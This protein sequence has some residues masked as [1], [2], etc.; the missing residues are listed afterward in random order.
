MIVGH[1][2]TIRPSVR[3]G[4][5]LEHSPL[6]MLVPDADGDL[7]ND[8]GSRRLNHI[9]MH[10]GEMWVAHVDNMQTWPEHQTQLLFSTQTNNQAIFVDKWNGSSWFNEGGNIDPN[11][12]YGGNSPGDRWRPARPYLASDGE[13]LYLAY[14]I[15]VGGYPYLGDYRANI[16]V[17]LRRWD[18][19]SWDLIRQFTP[20]TYNFLD[21][22]SFFSGNL[23]CLA[24]PEAVGEPL[25]LWSENGSTYDGTGTPGPT[26]GNVYLGRQ[27][28][29]TT[30]PRDAFNYEF[31]AVYDT[32][33]PYLFHAYLN[34]DV[35]HNVVA[36]RNAFTGDVLQYADTDLVDPPYTT[37]TTLV[38]PSVS[39][40][41]F[42]DGERYVYYVLVAA[43]MSGF[44][45]LPGFMLQVP[46]DGSAPFE[47]LDNNNAATSTVAYGFFVLVQG[48]SLFT[49]DIFPEADNVWVVG[50]L[51]VNTDERFFEEP[52]IVEQYDR[53]CPLDEDGAP[54]DQSGDRLT[55]PGWRLASLDSDP[56]ASPYF[57]IGTTTVPGLNDP[58]NIFAMTST[59]FDGEDMY[60]VGLTG[61]FT[62]FTGT[63]PGPG[64]SQYWS[65]RVYK[66]AIC[67][68]C[69]TCHADLRPYPVLNIQ[70]R[71]STPL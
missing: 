40:R 63:V 17:V 30:I 25:V 56:N 48:R 36:M 38:G 12:H 39:K 32:D 62:G 15:H 28:G 9:C 3:V 7:V 52:A 26:I 21:N 6:Q 60:V 29:S 18:G 46:A 19:A 69:G 71:S 24:S 66:V 16:T 57:G 53:A 35:G 37:T 34:D 4:G 43:G 8:D 31:D 59:I 20:K 14:S 54:G 58:G 70:F 44:V 41:R 64:P 50:P 27:D 2:D 68:G 1:Y 42:W 55:V 49:G 67:R 22:T 45:G 65:H 13:N 51:A 23:M 33:T 11:V 47:A 61:R 5:P 10:Q